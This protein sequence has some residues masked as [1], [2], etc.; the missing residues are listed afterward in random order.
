MLQQQLRNKEMWRG[1]RSWSRCDT[2]AYLTPH[3]AVLDSNLLPVARVEG[4]VE[5][6]ELVP[7]IANHLLNI[8]ES[9]REQIKAARLGS[10]SPPPGCPEIIM[11]EET[12]E[13][14]KASRDQAAGCT[15]CQRTTWVMPPWLPSALSGMQVK[16]KMEQV[17]S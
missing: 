8:Q 17:R 3:V 6:T 11:Q 12:G 9:E 10:E 2:N 1:L 16:L 4:V 13:S 5:P 7:R 14:R 15:A